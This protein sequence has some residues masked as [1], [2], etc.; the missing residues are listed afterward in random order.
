MRCET[1]P[2]ERLIRGLLAVMLGSFAFS[3]LDNLWCA[4]PAATCATFLLIGT[5]TGWCPTNLLFREQ[6]NASGEPNPFG[7]PEAPQKVKF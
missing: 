1:T 5:I 3:S 4:I 6:V 2:V 7:I